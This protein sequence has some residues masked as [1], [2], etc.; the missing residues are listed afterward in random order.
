[1]NQSP[2]DPAWLDGAVELTVGQRVT[3]EPLSG[4][5]AGSIYSSRIERVRE[6]EL[7]VLSPMARLEV[8][9]V[10]LGTPVRLGVRL[11][12][13][14]FGANVT[15]LEH[16]FHPEF[17]LG[18][19]HPDVLQRRNQRAFYRLPA[20]IQPRS[21]AVVNDDGAREQP[22]RAT[23]VNVSGG[24]VEL[25]APEPARSGQLVTILFNIEG[26]P[27]R[28]LAQVV[29]VQAPGEGRFNHRVH[30]QFLNLD[31]QVR[32]RIIRYIFRQQLELLRRG[33]GGEAAA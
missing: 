14:Y 5:A 23:I 13:R 16:V 10:P 30:C 3:L 33:V 29:A 24:E 7:Y 26:V 18:L 27:L 8:I 11:D 6:R 2:A 9:S 32:E 1:M 28:S 12:T 25:V 19:T 31:W 17:L 15:V 22:L 4:P 21:A 20:I